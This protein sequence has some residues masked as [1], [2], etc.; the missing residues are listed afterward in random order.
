MSKQSQH[1]SID[2]YHCG[3]PVDKAGEFVLSIQ[4]QEREFCCPGCLAVATII[5]DD[6]LEQFYQFRSQLNR[7]PKQQ[8]ESFALYD[9]D[10]IQQSFVEY[11]TAIADTQFKSLQ[12]G[13]LQ[14]EPLKKEPLQESSSSEE[15]SQIQESTAYLLLDDITCA[16]CVWLIEQHLKSI[17]GVISVSV[18]ADTHQC[19]VRW[20]RQQVSLSQLM[21]S[22]DDIG[23][24]PHPFTQDKNEEQQQR[25]QRMALMRLGVAAFGMMQ[26]GMVAIGLHA[27]AIQGIDDQWLSLLRW[28]S[29]IVATPVVVFSAQPFW[30]TAWK[31]L[32]LGQLTMEVPVSIAIILAYCASVWATVMGTGEVYF[33]SV[34]MFT[35]FLLWGRYLEMRTRYKNRRQTHVTARLL[36]LVV[37]RVLPDSTAFTVESDENIAK[38]IEEVVLAELQ[39]GDYV[40]IIS[41]DSIPCDGEVVE[42][43]SSVNESL[44]T[45]E[46]D[47]VPKQVGDHVIAGTVNMDGVL[48]IK[49][50]ATQQQT[51]LSTIERLTTF[52]EQDK[53]KVQELANTVSRY[54]VGA[55]L[56]VSVAVYTFWHFYQPELAF[57]IM[58]SVLVVTCPCALSLATPTV[59]TATISKMRAHGL[60]VIKGHVI[61]TLTH[62]NHAVF[63][64]TGTLTHGKPCVAEVKLIDS[65]VDESLLSESVSPLSKEQVLAIAAALE[66]GSSHPIA[67]AFTQAQPEA[68]TE[69]ATEA[70]TEAKARYSAKSQTLHTG[71][72]VEGIVHIDGQALRYFLGKPDFLHNDLHLP[73]AGQWLLLSGVL[74]GVLSEALGQELSQELSQKPNEKA[75]ADSNAYPI[76]W[77][78]LSD[79]L[80][81]TAQQAISDFQKKGIAV[82][83]LSGDNV[84]V[85]RDM[86]TTLGVSAFH[87]GVMPEE[88]LRYIRQQQTQQK[89]VLMVGDGINDVPVLAGADVSIAMGSASDFAR[90]HADAIL[91]N[92]DL[93]V[94]AASVGIAHRCKKIMRQNI[95]WALAYN[96]TALPLAAAGFIPPYLAAIGMSLSSLIV[97]VNALRV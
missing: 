41:G 35:F 82:D 73:S 86:A 96:I 17:Q 49:T 68:K 89:T 81:P 91:L 2:C 71:A 79:E 46:A 90:T 25:Y 36:P 93:T 50:T 15:L 72:G 51:R 22:L 84:T 44:I 20:N 83:M 29:L 43:H 5:N 32:L 97:V 95:T 67:H 26:V 39:L 11:H 42:G 28:V 12:T 14:A 6:G 52:A 64:K 59:L 16:A 1:S 66:S 55:V 92:N 53:P 80:R 19:A 76:A 21:L 47:P 70:A 94:L 10:D 8:K 40:H 88:K 18:N 13:F 45:G 3:L 77:I 7:K 60:L 62:V 61:E 27:G 34:S 58:L 24:R 33:D 4:Q 74:S 30:S 78:R 75:L 56:I 38:Q 9:R 54:F 23:Y 31:N 69:A 63:D 85:V 87:A 37:K 57:W 65:C 48:L